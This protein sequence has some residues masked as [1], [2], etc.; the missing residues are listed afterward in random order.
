MN[1]VAQHALTLLGRWRKNLDD[2]LTRMTSLNVQ[3]ASVLAVIALVVGIVGIYAW[4]VI[5]KMTISPDVQ[6]IQN[7]EKKLPANRRDLWMRIDRRSSL[8]LSRITLQFAMFSLL[9]AGVLLLLLIMNALGMHSTVNPI[10]EFLARF[11]A[12]LTS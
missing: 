3:H 10:A 11:E 6:R 4:R 7:L 8:V 2:C 12:D 5:R 9:C 1:S